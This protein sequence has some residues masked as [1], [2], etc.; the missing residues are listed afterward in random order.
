MRNLISIIVPVYNVEKDL[1]NCIESIIGQTYKNLEIILVDDESTDNCPQICD[2]YAKKDPRIK[3]VHQKNAGSSAARNA[4]LTLASGEYIGFVDSDDIISNTMYEILL[5]FALQYQVDVVSCLH[6]NIKELLYQN[7]Y[8]TLKNNDWKIFTTNILN[9]YTACGYNS[10]WRRLYKRS[11][12]KDI[13]FVVG[14]IDEDMLF[15]FQVMKNCHSLLVVNK[16]LYYWNQTTISISRSSVRN[17][18]S[19]IEEIY[20]KYHQIQPNSIIA[21]NL[22]LRVIQFQYRTI[23]RACLYGIAKECSKQEYK[24]VEKAFIRNIRTNLLDILKSH[25]FRPIDKVQIIIMFIHLPS[26]K[27]IYKTI[28]VL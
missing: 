8:N 14:V 11:V 20:E 7:S 3:V 24:D 10:V 9:H 28:K 17:L 27:Y 1:K 2:E 5:N 19:S 23:T 6:T 25:L 15:S 4:G 22:L 13:Q 26:Y 18:H 12:I 16:Y 21:H